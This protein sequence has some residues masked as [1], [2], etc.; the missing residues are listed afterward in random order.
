MAPDQ[1]HHVAGDLRSVTAVHPHELRHQLGRLTASGLGDK[2][3]HG[4]PKLIVHYRIPLVAFEPWCS[5]PPDL[6]NDPG[7]LIKGLNFSAEFP[8]EIG[9]DLVCSVK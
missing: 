1:I 7:I 4:V 8:P 2:A 3:K 9:N 6:A 5:V